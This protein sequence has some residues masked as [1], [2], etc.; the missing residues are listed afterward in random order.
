MGG[1]D[2][3]HDSLSLEEIARHLADRLRPTNPSLA[4]KVLNDPE[5]VRRD[6]GILKYQVLVRLLPAAEREW[7]A[8]I[9]A[10][11]CQGGREGSDDEEHAGLVVGS[12]P[13]ERLETLVQ[14]ERE[15]ARAGEQGRQI[16]ADQ[17]TYKYL[18]ERLCVMVA[19][20]REIADDE[21]LWQRLKARPEGA[22]AFTAGQAAKVQSVLWV[23][24][25]P[26]LT[27]CGYHTPPEPPADELVARAATVLAAAVTAPAGT[28]ESESRI[29]AARARLRG[30][31]RRI[32]EQ[33]P[34]QRPGNEEAGGRFRRL[35]RRAWRGCRDLL[36]AAA[37]ITL[38]EFTALALDAIDALVAPGLG[39]ALRILV[40]IAAHQ[41]MAS[42]MPPEGVSNEP[43][44]SDLMLY[45]APIDVQAVYLAA[46]PLALRQAHA[47]ADA[48]V[49][50]PKSSEERARIQAEC[51]LGIMTAVQHTQR[52]SAVLADRFGRQVPETA[53]A[54]FSAFRRRLGKADA[55]ARQGAQRDSVHVLITELKTLEREAVGLGELIH[56]ASG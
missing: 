56:D 29:D 5:I 2:H 50:A 24:L 16:W 49:K 17:E 48:L 26:L 51:R 34:E 28:Q 32:E 25:P 40:G 20:I 44:V 7:L 23:S 3:G 55:R 36:P 10:S 21:T 18:R 22:P 37:A 46:L 43:D 45:D 38:G 31:A 30:F 52:I 54:A 53:Q 41:L 13:R 47:S 15:L 4:E 14:V 11:Q 8:A 6:S 27:A 33:L 42:F 12:G 35:V 19:T 1:N 9:H 39:T